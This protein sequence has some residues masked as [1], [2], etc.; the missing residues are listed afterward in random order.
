MVSKL[1]ELPMISR[2]ALGILATFVLGLAV[3]QILHGQTYYSTLVGTLRD[4]TG[5]VVPN[6][7]VTAIE[8]GTGVNTSGTS[9][10]SGE[11]RI[12]NL[13]PGTYSVQATM[14][15]FKVKV[16]TDVRLVAAQATRV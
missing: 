1:K 14:Q 9:N 11:Y 15:G 5:A 3:P 4:T 6:A 2:K 10:S 16:A 13:R 7:E 12:E 8:A